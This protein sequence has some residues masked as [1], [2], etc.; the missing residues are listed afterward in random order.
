ML[1]N[2]SCT[3]TVRDK[4]TISGVLSLDVAEGLGDNEILTIFQTRRT[5]SPAILRIA[6]NHALGNYLYFDDQTQYVLTTRK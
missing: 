4:I 1:P 3:Q 5:C 6:A 2:S